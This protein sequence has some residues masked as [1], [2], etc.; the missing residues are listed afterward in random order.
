VSKILV[1]G[2]TEVGS[3]EEQPTRDNRRDDASRHRQEFLLRRLDDAIFQNR[4]ADSPMP[5]KTVR[6]EARERRKS[7]K[8]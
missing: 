4:D 3:A 2:E 6:Q 1:S 7:C 8:S 5:K